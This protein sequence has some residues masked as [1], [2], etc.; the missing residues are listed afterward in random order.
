MDYRLRVAKS[1]NEPFGGLNIFFVGDHYQ[2]GPVSDRSLFMPL[3]GEIDIVDQ[4]PNVNDELVA[5][6]EAIAKDARSAD[7]AKKAEL[8]VRRD[9][10]TRQMDELGRLL[11][12][13]VC[14]ASVFFSENMRADPGGRAF[15]ELLKRVRSGTTTVDDHH[16]LINQALTEADIV[17][18]PDRWLYATLLTPTNEI[19]REMGIKRLIHL[20]NH[21]KQRV[22]QW[23][24]E[25]ATRYCI[26]CTTHLTPH[27]VMAKNIGP[28]LASTSRTRQ[29][30]A[31][32]FAACP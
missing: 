18:D 3:P 24:S 30:L 22:I 9:R 13:S 5:N 19:V 32:S 14:N 1:C 31:T 10:M 12:I 21:T 16:T 29:L 11:W 20:A 28:T 2:L 26:A 4:L 15:V 8:R 27:A 25:Y 6:A 17:A 7:K 23:K